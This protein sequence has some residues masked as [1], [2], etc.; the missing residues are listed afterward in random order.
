LISLPFIIEKWLVCAL[1][2]NAVK[3][4]DFWPDWRNELNTIEKR[5]PS[6]I[7]TWADGFEGPPDNC[8]WWA[9]VYGELLLLK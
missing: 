3:L 6:L 8:I 9:V 4:S 5:H 7:I 2:R 1:P